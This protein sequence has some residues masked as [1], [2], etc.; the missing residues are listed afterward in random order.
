MR[1]SSFWLMRA[2][3]FARPREDQDRVTDRKEGVPGRSRA[4][5]IVDGLAAAPGHFD[6]ELQVARG[7]H[8]DSVD[9]IDLKPL[10]GWE[11][12]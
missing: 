7:H 3:S 1:T 12:R 4:L 9:V 2:N 8:R 6:A 5:E 10:A 11:I